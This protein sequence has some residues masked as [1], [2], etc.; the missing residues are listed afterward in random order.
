MLFHFDAHLISS[1]SRDL[2]TNSPFFLL[3]FVCFLP[4]CLQRGVG[5]GP[6]ARAHPRYQVPG[7]RAPG[8]GYLT[9]FHKLPHVVGVGVNV[10]LGDEAASFIARLWCVSDGRR[11]LSGPGMGCGSLVPSQTSLPSA[12]QGRALGFL[13]THARRG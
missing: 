1:C 2:Q 12:G 9:V 7:C 10:Q 11:M 3:L 8:Q 5:G 6:C 13:Q 4:T